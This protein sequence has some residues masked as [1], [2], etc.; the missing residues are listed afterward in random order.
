M[1]LVDHSNSIADILALIAERQSFVVTSHA[2]PDGDAIGSALGM[3]HLLEALGKH[4]DVCFSDPVPVVFQHLPGADR[5]LHTIPSIPADIAIILECD[6]I[7]RTGFDRIDA[8]FVL[9]ID[10]H[11]SGKN[12]ADY[13]WINPHACAVGA[14]VYEIAVAS[15]V[16]ITPAMATCLYA[17]LITDT[18]GFTYASTKA[19]TFAFAEHL[20]RSGAD[21]AGV[22]EAVYFSNSPG[23]MRLL[24]LALNRMQIAG[25][26]AWSFVSLADMEA[27]GADVEDCEGVANYL[28]AMS[29]IQASCFLRELPGGEQFRLSLRS[30]G[31]VDVA[32]VATTFSGG[33]H[34]N[35]SGGTI[36]GPLESA[37]NR[38]LAGL[39]AAC[40]AHSPVATG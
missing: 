15:G 32:A 38:L 7:S 8:H 11:L 13:N 29:G 39:Q 16:I 27:A 23:K 31:R 24:G 17:A 40:E 14:M 1:P 20:L 10:H 21:A 2:R 5:I 18:G 25:H 4:V 37:K 36:D 28:V 26:I 22:S 34:R 3:M 19:S 33:G 9:N 35:A 12:F 30:K 6:S